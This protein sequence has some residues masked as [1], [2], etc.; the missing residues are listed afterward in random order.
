MRASGIGI[1]L[2]GG[3]LVNILLFADDIIILASSVEDLQI[4]S[5][6]LEV[7]CLHFKM[8]ISTPKSNMFSPTDDFQCILTDLATGEQNVLERVI[9]YKYL[10][11]H[12]FLSPG[13]TSSSRCADVKSRAVQYK[14]AILG[15]TKSEVN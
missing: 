6:I 2:P 11:I 5:G 14:N 8:K 1:R 12:Q 9:S 10:G 3:E 4:L 13:R 15:A 7:W